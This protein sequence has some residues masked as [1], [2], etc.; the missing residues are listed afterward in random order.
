MNSKMEWNKLLNNKRVRDLKQNSMSR[1]AIKKF[2]PSDDHRNEFE[3]DYDRIVSSSSVRRLQDKAQV[4][5]LQENDFTRTRLTH[6]LEVSAIARSLGLWLENVLIEKKE[7]NAS[8]IGEIPALLATSGLVHD[9]GNPPFGH[10]GEDVIKNWFKEWF[11]NNID[12]ENMIYKM[13]GEEGFIG[14]DKGKIKIEELSD[15]MT[16]DGNAQSLRIVS[17]LQ[18]LNDQYGINFTLGT[19]SSIIKY[20]WSSGESEG[21]EKFGY[22]YKDKELALDI[23]NNT[24]EKEKRKNPL[25]YFLEAADDI[26]Y[27]GADI[28]DGVKKKAIDWETAY[29]LLKEELPKIDVEFTEFFIELDRKIENAEKRKHPDKNLTSVQNFRVAIQG[30]L[31]KYIKLNFLNNY[32]NIIKGHLPGEDLLK[33]SSKSKKVRKV[34]SSIQASCFSDKEVLT[35]ELV[36]DKVINDLLDI[37]VNAILKDVEVVENDQR[38][39]LAKK[40]HE[41]LI[42]M[43]SDNFL[44]IMVL[45]YH[46]NNSTKNFNDLNLYERLLLVTDFISGMTDSYAVDLHQKLSGVKLP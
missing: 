5:P 23:I 25:A 33:C 43:I 35:L 24:T 17:K 42:H 22:F 14:K 34:L 20:P 41:K 29:K 31:I 46:E 15:F 44:Y 32:E 6:S 4:F 26:A 13:A 40:K 2:G 38:K 36:G 16:F 21:K 9:L 10:Y 8:R 45:D 19:L 12:K 1:V 27:L 3:K 7:I 28:E 11:E 18:F 30:K 37:F 39:M